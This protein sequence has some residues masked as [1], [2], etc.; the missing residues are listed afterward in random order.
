MDV[1][2]GSVLLPE[3]EARRALAG[4]PLRLLLIAPPYRAVGVGVLRALRIAE[5]DGVT[6]IAAGY[7][8]YERLKGER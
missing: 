5:R 1:P 4:R 6:E 8:R 2:A 7:D 3:V